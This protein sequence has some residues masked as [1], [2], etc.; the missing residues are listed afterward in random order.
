[1]FDWV[2]DTLGWIG[3]AVSSVWENS[4]TTTVNDITE[5]VFK[6][7]FEWIYGLVY[8]GIAD[9]FEYINGTSADIFDLAWV[10]AFIVL[11]HHLGWMLFACGFVVSIF[12]MAIASDSGRGNIKDTCLNTVKGFFA[13]SLVTVA[14]Q[15]LYSLCVALQ[16]SFAHDLL[17][18]FISTSP[19]NVIEAAMYV[20]EQLS[21]K[22]TVAGLLLIV[23]FGY[24]TIKVILANIKRGGILL[25]QIAVGSLYLFSVPRGFTDGFYSWVK[26]V[27]ATCLTAFLQTTILYLGLLTFQTHEILALG[28]CLSANEV[29]R[30]AQMFGLDTA[31]HINMTSV[32]SAVGMGSRIARLVAAKH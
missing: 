27:I 23:M 17:S 32:S 2:G 6:A 15:R 19:G 11:F 16:G 20:I 13:A 30:V 1:M 3:D 14:P 22:K 7:F 9:I 5:I 28:I 18:S 21:P 31:A 26:Q 24:C 8:G 29:P 12:D 10:Q 25:C 4:F